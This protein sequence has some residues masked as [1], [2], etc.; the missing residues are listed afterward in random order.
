MI[1][2]ILAKAKASFPDDGVNL[3]NRIEHTRYDSDLSELLHTGAFF[4]NFPY[5]SQLRQAEITSTNY[6]STQCNKDYKS[7]GKYGAGVLLFW[8]ITHRE[9]LGFVILEKG[10]SCKSVY[11]VLSTRFAIMPKYVIYDNACNLYEVLADLTLVCTQPKSFAICQYSNC[12]RR[13]SFQKPHQLFAQLRLPDVPR[14]QR[15]L[16]SD[17]RTK[18]SVS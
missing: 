6:D 12:V 16:L 7:P 2:S 11:E 1:R 17:T 4:P 3:L 8:C 18:T 9:C 5:H 14:T 10:E 15:T 13:C